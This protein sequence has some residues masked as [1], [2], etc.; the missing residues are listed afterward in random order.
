M[1]KSTR[2]ALF[3]TVLC[4][5]SGAYSGYAREGMWIPATLKSQDSILKK[6]GL[7]MPVNQLYNDSVGA[8]NHAVAL[9]GNGCTASFI[10]DQGLLLTNHHCGYGYAQKLSTPEH[11]F[12]TDG[13][14]AMSRGQELPCPGLTITITRKM[15]NVSKY[16]LKGITDS[17]PENKREELITA[18]MKEMAKAYEYLD[19]KNAKVVPFYGGN[20]YWVM[21]T[22]TFKDVRLVAFPPNGIGKFGADRDNWMWPRETGDFSMFRVY[23]NSQNQPADYSSSNVAYRPDA[24]LPVSTSGYQQGTFAMV[25]GY[26]YRTEEYLTSF[27]LGRVRDIMYPIRV[28][29]RGK[30]L[31]I[32]DSAMRN[33]PATFLKYAA[34][35]AS[36]SNGYKKWK[37][38]LQGLANNK[39]MAKKQ[40]YERLF[41]EMAAKDD[42]DTSMKLLLPRMAAA[43]NGN[44]N[45]LYASEYIREAVFGVEIIRQASVLQKVMELYRKGADTPSMLGVMK[46]LQEKMDAFYKDYIPALDKK[47]FEALMPVYLQ[48]NP[49][50]VAPGLE[51]QLRMSGNSYANWANSVVLGSVLSKSEAVDELLAHI[52]P[53]DTFEILKDPAYRLYAAVRKFEKQKILPAMKSYQATMKPLHRKFVAKEIQY[54]HAPHALYPDANQ[55][56]RVA[57]GAVQ[58]LQL[59]NSNRWQTNLD[60]LIA[61]H[62]ASIA[63]MTVP[64]ALRK[65]YLSHSYGQ[66]AE[67]GKM[68]VNFLTTCQTTG[69]NSGSPVLN[70]HG[71]LIGLNFDRPWQGT[72]SDFYYS[73]KEC[74][75][76]SVD[77]RYV[78]FLVEQYGHAGWLL[79]EMKFVK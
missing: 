22:Q 63:E 39:V 58:P 31:A 17:I 43:V 24:F 33:D 34:K 50:V 27:E 26:P 41:S 3:I 37:G 46:V 70:G 77:I 9:F 51:E 5:L 29:I 11:N 64:E 72:M 76:I 7:I 55:T 25:Y 66:W 18:R 57:F 2:N 14:W 53:Q 4:L 12:L 45:A 10:S 54:P 42:N 60:D 62:D 59:E 36:V 44:K 38:A 71:Q 6:E 75:N 69:G 48:Q 32:W 61:R 68:P 20:Q 21:V 67:N 28:T 15:V 47:V 65:L 19:K 78:M 8:L 13:F 52:R 16:V 40:A 79:Q 74:R 35:Q 30:K 23:A 49:N 1:H 56:L 73:D